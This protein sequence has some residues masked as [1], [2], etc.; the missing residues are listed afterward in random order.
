MR[1]ILL[2]RKDLIV[3]AFDEELI[4]SD[5]NSYENILVLLLDGNKFDLSVILGDL[6]VCEEIHQVQTEDRLHLLRVGDQSAELFI[7]VRSQYAHVLLILSDV[8]LLDTQEGGILIYFAG[9]YALLGFCLE[10]GRDVLEESEIS[11]QLLNKLVSL[12]K[13]GRSLLDS[14]EL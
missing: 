11:L 6:V 1:N 2:L 8:L 13:C 5:R 10:A 4:K 12:G 9:Q 14:L 7:V 3:R